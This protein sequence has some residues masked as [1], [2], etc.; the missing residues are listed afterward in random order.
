MSHMI[1]M[2]VGVVIAREEIDSPWQDYTWRPVSII[3]GAPQ[4]TP[5]K[6]LMRGEGWVHYHAATLPLELHRKETQAYKENLESGEPSLYVVLSEDDDAESSH[7]FEVHLVTASPF[8]AQDYLDSGE[9]VV[10]PV[11]MSNTLISWVRA[12]VETHHV[13]EKFRKR[14]RD[15]VKLEDHKFGQEPI[16]E[17][18]DKLNGRKGDG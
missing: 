18:R 6:E 13:E 17:I 15:E 4:F 9:E 12:F 8:E 2:P 14:R 10:E 16:F 7:P 11:A 5:W 3:P 1:S